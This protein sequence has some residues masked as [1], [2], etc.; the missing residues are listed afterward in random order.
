MGKKN[1]WGN[2]NC[3]QIVENV[4]PY[5]GEVLIMNKR[6]FANHVRWCKKNPRYEEIKKSTQEK[7][8][9]SLKKTQEYTLKCEVCGKEYKIEIT[10]HIYNLGKY[11]KTCSVTCAKQ[12]SAKHTNKEEKIK[13]LRASNI[14]KYHTKDYL[15]SH[16][17]IRYDNGIYVKQCENC[18][19]EFETSSLKSKYCSDECRTFSRYYANKNLQEFKHIKTIYKHT[20]HFNFSLNSYPDAFDFDLINKYGWYKAKNHGNN[21]NGVSRDHMYSCNMGFTNKIDPYLIS[22]PANCK[23]L[24]HNENSGKRDKSSITLEELKQRVDNWNKKYGV[25]ENKINYDILKMIGFEFNK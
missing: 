21:L 19:K 11:K 4:C 1:H 17:I 14:S 3:K 25:Y 23:L 24:R 5:C 18:G 13:K 12:L 6:S 16:K 15:L 22:H 20:C 9:K 8:S 7:L 10:E 2:D